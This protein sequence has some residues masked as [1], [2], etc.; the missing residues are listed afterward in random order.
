MPLSQNSNLYVHSCNTTLSSQPSSIFIKVPFVFFYHNII[1]QSVFLS[2]PLPASYSWSRPRC[3]LLHLLFKCLYYHFKSCSYAFSCHKFTIFILFYF[4]I[5][6]IY[7]YI[8]KSTIENI[9][10]FLKADSQSN[11]VPKKNMRSDIEVSVS[12][13]LPFPPNALHQVMRDG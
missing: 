9:E 10:R 4:L 13:E 1:E 6:Y 7:I 5:G 12:S 11:N 3:L 8:Y 2:H